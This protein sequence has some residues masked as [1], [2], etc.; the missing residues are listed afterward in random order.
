[1]SDARIQIWNVAA[2]RPLTTLAGHAQQVTALTFDPDG[3]LLASY[4]W[5][6]VLR[7][8]D[9]PTGRPLLQLP[10]TVDGQP[11]FSLDGRWLG[12]VQHGE[13]TELLEVTPSHEY[14][15]LVSSEG[16]GRGSY[17]YGDISPDG[18]LLAI[19][20]N[21]GTRLWDLRTGREVAALPTGTIYA[22]F[23]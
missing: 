3:G 16:A 21:E 20:M 1:G 15:T 2:R 5:D 19:G 6:G 11:R 10:L 23:D 7:L 17:N 8:W 4:A 22:F 12:A 9:T 13:Q 14:R 18:R